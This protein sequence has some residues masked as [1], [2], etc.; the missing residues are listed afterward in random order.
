LDGVQVK[1]SLQYSIK[2]N[3][4]KGRRVTAGDKFRLFEVLDKVGEHGGNHGNQYTK[5]ANTKT[6]VLANEASAK[7]TAKLIGTSDVQV[8]KMRTILAYAD[9]EDIEAVKDDT[10]SIVKRRKVWYA[11]ITFTKPRELESLHF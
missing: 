9:K 6:L 1:Q 7:H 11:G 3:K 5:S 4:N 8:N 2:R 10:L